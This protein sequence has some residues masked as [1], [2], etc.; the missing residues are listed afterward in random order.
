[1]NSRVLSI[2][3]LKAYK[4]LIKKDKIDGYSSILFKANIYHSKLCTK[5]LETELNLRINKRVNDS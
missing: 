1:M 5:K 3:F 4:L 2:F